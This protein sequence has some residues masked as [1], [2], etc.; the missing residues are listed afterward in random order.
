MEELLDGNMN[1][2]M[3]ENC[4]NI[5]NLTGDRQSTGGIVG[6]NINNG[7]IDNCYF[8]ENVVGGE[9]GNIIEG[10]MAKTS[11]EMKLLTSTLGAAFKDDT[12]N[13]NNGYPILT[14][15]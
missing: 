6:V 15:Q 9:N 14:W 4:Y 12:N 5:G 7:R 13:I 11:E 10:S 2:S 8:L 3:V 1:E